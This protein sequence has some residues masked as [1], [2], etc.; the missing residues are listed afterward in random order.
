MISPPPPPP[1]P[2]SLCRHPPTVLTVSTLTPLVTDFPR[3]LSSTVDTTTGDISSAKGIIDG[4]S[5]RPDSPI[6]DLL[7]KQNIIQPIISPMAFSGLIDSTMNLQT[8]INSSQHTQ[9]ILIPTTTTTTTPTYPH[10]LYSTTFSTSS[11][12]SLMTVPPYVPPL[13][14][15]SSPVFGLLADLMLPPQSAV[16]Q[17]FSDSNTIGDDELSIKN[18][19]VTESDESMSIV[20]SPSSSISMFAIRDSSNS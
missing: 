18:S 10:S 4:F 20:E 3:F 9:P 12:D 6:S 15:S 19:L 7:L 2:P 17:F 14:R 11:S 1:P 8:S 16:Q 13:L 5:S